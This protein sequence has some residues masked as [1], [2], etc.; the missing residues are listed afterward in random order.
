MANQSP[1]VEGMAG[2]DVDSPGWDFDLDWLDLLVT[3][4][5]SKGDKMGDKTSSSSSALGDRF[6]S[7][8]W[9]LLFL[10]VGALALPSG[11]VQFVAAIAVGSAMLALNAAR[12]FASI[13]VSW[14]SI[15]LGAAMVLAG[16]GALGGL[17]MDVFVLFFVIAG[18]V[19][20]GTALV[21]PSRAAMAE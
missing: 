11:T 6:D 8:G 1:E 7:V 9:G 10:L 2:P 14:F 17:H 20:I 5:P 21:K 3:L 15:I 13:S 12:A 4:I 18:A 16:A 19:T